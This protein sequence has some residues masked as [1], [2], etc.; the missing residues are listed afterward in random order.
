MNV[1]RRPHMFKA[2]VYPECDW[3]VT[4]SWYVGSPYRTE[5][6]PDKTLERQITKHLVYVHGH[7]VVRKI[8]T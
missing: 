2:C 4:T 8:F 6:V 7:K 1:E 5:K 3:R